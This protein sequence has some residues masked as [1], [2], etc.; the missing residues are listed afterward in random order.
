MTTDETAA[1]PFAQSTT[2]SGPGARYR[3]LVQGH[4]DPVPVALPH[5]GKAWLVHRYEDVR[6]ILGDARFSRALAVEAV[7]E[8]LPSL[9]VRTSL[10][11]LDPPDHTR[12]RKC[13]T[14]L[15]SRNAAEAMRPRVRALV[16]DR[17]RALPEAPEAFDA[18]GAFC[19]PVP[20]D[21]ICELLGVPHEDR[22]QFH[23]WADLA[24]SAA[25]EPAVV[26]A[27][28]DD[29]IGYFSDILTLRANRPGDGLC[30]G[31]AKL[32]AAGELDQEEAVSLLA[33]ILVAGYETSA[34]QLGFYLL[35]LSTR[36]GAY[37]QL[38]DHPDDVAEAVADYLRTT[39]FNIIGGAL[40]RVAR[41]PVRIGSVTVQPG[42]AVLPSTDAANIHSLSLDPRPVHLSFGAGIHRCLG[43]WLAQAELEEALLGLVGRY[44]SISLA[45]DPDE[46]RLKP[47]SVVRSLQALPLRG[48][49]DCMGYAGP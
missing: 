37:Q 8:M 21:V 4:E 44:D 41:E 22:E 1:F 35:D 46:L 42:E 39:P 24:I 31:L 7:S 18:V 15:F 14:G 20:V 5:G 33:L 38:R 11:S 23:T 40:A 43:V 13:V 10:L 6:L 9:L 29:L 34:S 47:G 45:V 2:L 48:H 25:A 27:A 17:A 36:P 16:R 19:L 3:Q 12:I 28:H 49:G 30:S 26:Y 32:I